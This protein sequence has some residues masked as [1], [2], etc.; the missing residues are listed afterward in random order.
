LP[1]IILWL[2]LKIF[3]FLNLGNSY[4]KNSLNILMNDRHLNIPKLT[5]RKKKEKNDQLCSTAL[6]ILHC[7]SGKLNKTQ[8]FTHFIKLPSRDFLHK[9]TN[10]IS[11][12]YTK[13]NICLLNYNLLSIWIICTLS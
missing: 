3:Y 12:F 8:Q 9:I 11:K 10:N 2:V 5:K 4:Q 13:K 6:F 7:K 1:T